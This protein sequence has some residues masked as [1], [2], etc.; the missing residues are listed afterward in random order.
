MPTVTTDTARTDMRPTVA[1][2]DAGAARTATHRREDA[3]FSRTL[4]AD[5]VVGRACDAGRFPGRRRVE[6]RANDRLAAGVHRLVL[7][8]PYIAR[9]A[10][11]AQFI[12]LYSA[13]PLRLMPRPFGVCEVSGD[14]VSIVF[15]VVGTGTEE[16]SRL[17]PGDGVDALGPL[18]RPYDLTRPANYVLVGG[19]LGVP[20]L[21]SAAQSL[22]TRDDC[23]VTALFGYRDARF[24][25]GIV[26]PYADRLESIV[27]A[28]GNVIDL[29]DR[30][31]EELLGSRLPPVIL[32]C[33][34]APMMK[35]VA[36]WAS[37]R[38]VPC[39]FSLEQRMG[40][41]YG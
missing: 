16:F 4:D 11:P 40:C 35:A 2:T 19:G 39:Q 18:G 12:D 22:S 36:D 34:P 33:G 1:S 29:L 6:V 27:N 25:D 17:S 7:R 15:A 41:G 13:N 26:R 31:E 32:S 14:E 23:R 8:D 37:T 24:A 9:H 30:L 20:P 21:I 38:G 10:G 28:E 5:V 3:V